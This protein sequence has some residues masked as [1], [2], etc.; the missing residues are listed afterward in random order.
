MNAPIDIQDKPSI[1]IVA[2]FAYGA[3]TGGDNG[4]I[5]GVERQTSLTARWFADRGYP[6]SLVTWDQGQADEVNID[7]VRVIKMCRR[8]D[9]VRGM[10][11]LHPRWTSL[12]RALRRADADVYYQN[13]A[14]YVTGQV[15]MWCRRR[16]RGFVYSVANDPDVDSRLPDMRKVRERVLYRY[17][18]RRADRIIVQTQS[19]REALH[20][21][22]GLDSVVIPMPC[23]DASGREYQPPTPQ[24]LNQARVLWIARI[25][26]QKRPDRLLD[27][28]ERCPELQFDLVGPA[29]GDDYSRRVLERARLVDNVTVHGSIPRAQVGD[30]YQRASCMCATSDFEGFPNTFLEAWS[31]GLPLVSTFDPDGLIAGRDLGVTA[32]DVTSLAAG[33]RG[34]LTS[35]DRWRRASENGRRYYLENHTVDAVL[36]RFE[37]VFLQCINGRKLRRTG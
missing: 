34:L 6:V 8:E 27:L 33:L 11:F 17:G 2:H 15:A 1:A 26:E 5:G 18:L 24:V 36:P 16:G 14:E 32:D 9:G 31:C 22:F 25:C 3:M 7:G 4:H 35:P 28:A 29:G 30:L 10:R 19:Q 23:P 37:Q 20:K 12:N 21:G 13:C